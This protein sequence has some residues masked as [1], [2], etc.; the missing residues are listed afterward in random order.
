M[1]S[2][3]LKNKF[4]LIISLAVIFNLTNIILTQWLIEIDDNLKS[5]KYEMISNELKLKDI[6]NN[7]FD[8]IPD[9]L[10][11]SETYELKSNLYSDYYND[12]DEYNKNFQPILQHLKFYLIYIREGF[13][14]EKN[15]NY[16]NELNN[17][18]KDF[19]DLSNKKT[20]V[21]LNFLKNKLK[22]ISYSLFY[23]REEIHNR[24]NKLISQRLHY[25]NNRY[26]I[27]IGL[28]I[29]QILNLLCLS[30]FCFFFF[31]KNSE[32]KKIDIQ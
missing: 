6:D 18:E 13:F 3:F 19:N 22:D 14:L 25:E 8:I 23:M 5:E 24:I 4:T 32:S 26:L 30:F 7:T 2:Y 29:T 15:N 10:K 9:L 31:S 28:V 21:K 11:M 1:N 16:S 20:T 27:N 12:N 17:I